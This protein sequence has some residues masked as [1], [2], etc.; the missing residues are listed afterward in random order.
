LKRF[1]DEGEVSITADSFVMAD[2]DANYPK[3]ITT[4]FKHFNLSRNVEWKRPYVVITP[5]PDG[6]VLV[7]WMEARKRQQ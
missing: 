5:T 6:K 4:F 3:V 2:F 1:I 7:T